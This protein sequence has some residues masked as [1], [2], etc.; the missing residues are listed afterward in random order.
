MSTLNHITYMVRDLLKYNSDD[1]N[2][3]NEHIKY[4]INTTRAKYLRQYLDAAK[5]K[6]PQSIKQEII[7]NLETQPSQGFSDKK[8]LVSIEDVPSIVNTQ[9]HYNRT[10]ISSD[11]NVVRSFTMT[12]YKR[13]AYT[14]TRRGMESLVYGAIDSEKLYLVSGDD[15]VLFLEKVRLQGV[16]EDPKSAWELSSDY[17][18]SIDFDDTEYPV[19]SAMVDLIVQ[20]VIKLLSIRFQIL[21]DKI[22]DADETS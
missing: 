21:E 14:G 13:L 6:V 1:S 4:L 12:S 3:T 22:N 9:S 2:I 18:S 7:L 5:R 8:Y 17:D 19:E 11:N 20:E 16:F 10:K 15:R